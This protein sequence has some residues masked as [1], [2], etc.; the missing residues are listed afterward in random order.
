MF[1]RQTRTTADKCDVDM[2]HVPYKGDSDAIKDM[3]SEVVDIFFTPVARP[4]VEGKL[5]KIIGI[6]AAKR[7]SATPAWATL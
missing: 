1:H 5:I 4:Q 7:A 6:A 2:T 3:I